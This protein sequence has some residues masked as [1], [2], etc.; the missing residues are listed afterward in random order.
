LFLS[1][2]NFGV[3]ADKKIQN[4]KNASNT[5]W[6]SRAY[7]SARC[8]AGVCGL[9]GM[10]YGLKHEPAINAKFDTDL[11]SCCFLYLLRNVKKV[12]ENCK[13]I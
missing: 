4:A 6:L 8:V 2:V 1:P 10:L 11:D 3:R 12:I 13:E 5:F 9:A 7:K